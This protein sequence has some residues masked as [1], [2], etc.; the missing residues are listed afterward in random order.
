[1][2]TERTK[3]AGK[4]IGEQGLIDSRLFEEKARSKRGSAWIRVDVMM[5]KTRQYRTD[6]RL[7]GLRMSNGFLAR[8]SFLKPSLCCV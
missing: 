3:D 4:G 1:M 6:D 7:Q 2:D 8:R 5:A